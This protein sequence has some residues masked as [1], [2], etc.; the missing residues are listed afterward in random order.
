MYEISD[1]VYH[2]LVLL[3]EMGLTITDL[4]RE[5]RRRH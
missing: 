5:L 4:E 3:E 1:L 2:G